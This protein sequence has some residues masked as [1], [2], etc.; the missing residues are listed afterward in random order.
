MLVVT[1][2]EGF[3]LET[4]SVTTAST[5]ILAAI[6]WV[7]VP[8]IRSFVW[9]TLELDPTKYDKLRVESFSRQHAAGKETVHQML[10]KELEQL[11]SMRSTVEDHTSTIEFVHS[12]VLKQAEEMRQLPS[13][14]S[15]IQASAASVSEIAKTMKEIHREVTAHG[16]KLAG[17]DGYFEGQRDGEEGARRIHKR[18]H[19]DPDP[20]DV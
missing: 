2:V 5:V 20:D 8:R 17:W 12:A 19:N 13:I 1:G 11:E 3:L 9:D 18:R 10:A 16:K 15:A 4:A 7:L 6:G 14:A